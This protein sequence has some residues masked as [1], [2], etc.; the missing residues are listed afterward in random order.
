MPPGMVTSPYGLKEIPHLV[1]PMTVQDFADSLYL[2]MRIPVSI[3]GHFPGPRLKDP[4][5]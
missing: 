2:S 1:L 3:L 4:Q 5:R